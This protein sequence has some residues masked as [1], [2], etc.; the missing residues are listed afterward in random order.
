M[1]IRKRAVIHEKQLKQIDFYQPS[2]NPTTLVHPQILRLH[3]YPN[4]TIIE[5]GSVEDNRSLW[6][7]VQRKG[8][9]KKD[10]ACE[11]SISGHFVE[12]KVDNTARDGKNSRVGLLSCLVVVMFHL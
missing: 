5:N 3:F 12:S 10:P 7:K 6:D 11:T 4:E 9:Q 2:G 1:F 8:K